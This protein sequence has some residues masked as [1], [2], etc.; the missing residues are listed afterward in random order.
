MGD[1]SNTFGWASAGE[2]SLAAPHLEYMRKNR[3]LIEFSGLPTGLTSVYNDASMVLRVNCFHATRPELE[4]ENTVVHRINGQVNLAGKPSYKDVGI[5]FYDSLRLAGLSDA[6]GQPGAADVTSCSDIIE[7]WRELIYQP[8]RGDAFGAVANYKAVAF[9]HMLQPVDL[10]PTA[11]DSEPTFD[12]PQATD[13]IVQSWM[14]Q[15]LFPSVIKY[16]EVDW[17]ES[18]VQVVDVT[19]KVDRYFRVAA[20]ARGG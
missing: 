14:L 17:K 7:A 6:S 3:W 20:G 15:G 2:Q 8:N 16:G 13:S 19:F 9:L 18:D 12:E 10:A 11:P 4:F 1:A 5:Q